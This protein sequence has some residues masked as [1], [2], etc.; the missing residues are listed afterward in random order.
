[1]YAPVNKGAAI[2]CDH[3]QIAVLMNWVEY[4]ITNLKTFGVS[5]VRG[6]FTFTFHVIKT[7]SLNWSP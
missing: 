6:H 4:C 7:T 1:M 3:F 2:E 5:A